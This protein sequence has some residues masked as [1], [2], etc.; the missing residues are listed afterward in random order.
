M[1][2]NTKG[3]NCR[4]LRPEKNLIKNKSWPKR[5]R[6]ASKEM[7]RWHPA[8]KRQ[9]KLKTEEKQEHVQETGLPT[10]SGAHVR[11]RRADPKATHRQ[12]E[13]GRPLSHLEQGYE[14]TRAHGKGY[15]TREVHLLLTQVESL[16]FSYRVKLDSIGYWLS[17]DWG[18]AVVHFSKIL[19]SRI[20]VSWLSYMILPLAPVQAE[21]IK[22]KS[23]WWRCWRTKYRTFKLSLCWAAE[24]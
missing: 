2:V 19:N 16:V 14:G 18:M 5:K 23:Y 20:Y 21:V 15:K 9:T 22:K 7:K 12:C 11:R 3:Q 6:M 24:H 1:V 17:K 13:S 10:A 8:R 4:F